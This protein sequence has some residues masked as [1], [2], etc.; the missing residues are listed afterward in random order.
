MPR[1]P[2]YVHKDGVVSSHPQPSWRRVVILTLLG[3]G[4]VIFGV[5]AAVVI[6]FSP[7][8]N[9]FKGAALPLFVMAV[10][11][12]GAYT[13][14]NSASNPARLSARHHRYLS[15]ETNHDH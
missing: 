9:P 11:M 10:G 12:A 7:E 1:M 5:S 2:L 4:S 14:Y 15:E 6:G 13:V 8:D 3:V